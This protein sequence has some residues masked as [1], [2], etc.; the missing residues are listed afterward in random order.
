TLEELQEVVASATRI[1]A[2]GSRHSF[3]GMADSD[4]LVSL[5]S[6]PPSIRIDVES[7]TVSFSAGVRY[8]ELAPVLAQSGWALRNLASLPHISV[9]GAVATG[10]HGSGDGNGSLGRAVAGL[11]VVSGSGDI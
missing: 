2:L 3:S 5:E 11:Q 9:A 7:E 6:L 1:R 4:E 8:G 10:T